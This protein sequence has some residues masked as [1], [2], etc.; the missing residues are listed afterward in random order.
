[1]AKDHFQIVKQLLEYEEIDVN[2]RDRQ[3]KTM[4]SNCIVEFDQQSLKNLELFLMEKR[5]DPNI[6]DFN[7]NTPLHHLCSWTLYRYLVQQEAED[8]KLNKEREFTKVDRVTLDA[9]F[10]GLLLYIFEMLNCN[11]LDLNL[12]NNKGETPLLTSIRE[13]NFFALDILLSFKTE[14]NLFYVNP[15]QQSILHSLA[16]L[17]SFGP[18]GLAVF[19]QVYSLLEPSTARAMLHAVDKSGF[20]PLLAAVKMFSKNLR[21]FYWRQ[22]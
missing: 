13:L 3:G 16:R 4:V 10:R 8:K 7:G 11:G 2:L 1:M 6:K 20:T 5:A 12:P 15:R 14:L 21:P 19:R 22:Y 18:E 17:L 9:E